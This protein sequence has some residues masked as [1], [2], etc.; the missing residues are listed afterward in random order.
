MVK[1]ANSILFLSFYYFLHSVSGPHP[2]P[3]PRRRVSD[4]DTA[5][6]SDPHGSGSTTLTM[7]LHA[8][9]LAH[10]MRL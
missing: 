9:P 5:K 3:D 4:P 6:V 7:S 2:D 1:I 8:L 10:S